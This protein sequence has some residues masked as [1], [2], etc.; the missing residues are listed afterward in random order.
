M[1]K[2]IVFHLM[3]GNSTSNSVYYS[4]K[5]I[6]FSSLVFVKGFEYVLI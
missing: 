1:K 5:S 3:V 4:D 2:V 6:L